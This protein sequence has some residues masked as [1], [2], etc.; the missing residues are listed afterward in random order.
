MSN[1]KKRLPGRPA[2]Y[3]PEFSTGASD[4]PH[5]NDPYANV[6]GELEKLFRGDRSAFSADVQP[7]GCALF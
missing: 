2:K 1:S 4:S 6:L 7:S 3:P 5:R